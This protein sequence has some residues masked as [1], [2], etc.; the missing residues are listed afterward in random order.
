MTDE[1][2]T[3]RLARGDRTR[4]DDDKTIPDELVTR[5]GRLFTR[6][7]GALYV[8]KSEALQTRLIRECHD[9]ATAGH[10]SRDKTVEQMQR[11]FFWHGMTTR[12]G[13]YVTTCDAC[14]RNKPSQRLIPGLLMS[15]VSPPRACHTWTMDLITQL[16]KSRSGNDAIVV[17]V[18]KFSKLRH[19]A[20]CK[21]T[22]SAP[23]LAQLFLRSESVKA[24][25]C[26]DR[27]LRPRIVRTG[28]AELRNSVNAV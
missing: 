9:L 22:I 28:C 16:S 15:I 24:A 6:N 2:Y 1:E 20:A 17:W 4:A 7:N 21:T 3:A 5:D 11:R 8:P 26:T 27:L 19:Y 13:E 12:V 18:C 10:L 14:Q 23:Q 25:R